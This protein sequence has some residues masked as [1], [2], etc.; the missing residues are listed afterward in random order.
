MKIAA[1]RKPGLISKPGGPR[2]TLP[3]RN[4][5]LEQAQGL[6][7]IHPQLGIFGQCHISLSK[8]DTTSLIFLKTK[9]NPED[10]D[11]LQVIVYNLKMVH[12]PSSGPYYF[13]KLETE[14]ISRKFTDLHTGVKVL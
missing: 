12:Q 9:E 8:C 6:Q 7:H 13:L 4:R 2:T 1:A 10:A 14:S 11:R 3:P 5:R